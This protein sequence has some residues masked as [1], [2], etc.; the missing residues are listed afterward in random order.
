M[1][2]NIKRLTA[3][4]LA[5]TMCLSLLSANVWAAKAEESADGVVAAQS[6]E[7]Q[8]T[9]GNGSESEEITEI[10]ATEGLSDNV[11]QPSGDD[12]TV[13]KDEKPIQGTIPEKEE[14]S[15]VEE[16]T[17]T[18][19]FFDTDSEIE[20]KTVAKLE[21]QES[22]DGV[23][24]DNVRWSF[25]SATGTLTISGNG[26]M[27]DYEIA[28]DTPWYRV[29]DQ[30]QSI[31]INVGVTTIGSYSFAA[32]FE[33][34][35]S[36]SIP[37]SV[38]SIGE[39]A[40]SGCSKL[41]HVTIPNGVKQIS[42]GAFKWCAGLRSVSIPKSVTYIRD[43][44]F[45]QC[46]GLTSIS[47]SSGLQEIGEDAFYQCTSLASI[48]IPDTVTSIDEGAFSECTGLTDV[49][50]SNKLVTI[51]ESAFHSCSSLKCIVIPESI[52]WIET[53]AFYGC[54]NLTSVILPDKLP[55]IDVQA[56]SE[57]PCQREQGGYVILGNTLV[58]YKGS[59]Q[60]LIIPDG[61]TGITSY[62][63]AGN[64]NITS[65]KIPNSV[66]IIGDYAFEGCSHLSNVEIPAGVKSIGYRAFYETPWQN[67]NTKDGFVI[68]N[69]I[70]IDWTYPNN[71]N[72][73]K[74]VTAIG[75]YTFY[76]KKGVSVILPE[77]LTSIQD[78][79]FSCDLRS[80]TIPS[81]VT[82][83]GD[84]AFAGCMETDLTILSKTAKFGKNVF[85]DC[86]N[87][88]IHGYRGS[89]A[90]AY[91]KEN[92]VKFVAIDDASP[93]TITASNAVRSFSVKAQTFKLNAKVKNKA[94]L[95]YQSSNKKVKVDKNGKVTLPAK[96]SGTVKVTITAAATKTTKKATKTITITVPTVTNV[97]KATAGKGQMTVQWKKNK[98]GKGYVV[99][100]TTDKKFKKGVKTVKIKMNATVK[101]TIKKLKKGTYYVRIRA[102]NGKSYSNWC[103]VKSVKVK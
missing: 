48:S 43:R 54:S 64:S 47:L 89:T 9:E 55:S 36:I 90:E 99:Q 87:I 18:E 26:A 24:G 1:K 35:S 16:T 8:V 73:P 83:I 5:M 101:T 100:Y 52:R 37:D 46:S 67:T 80:L 102:M 85:A 88:T 81:G 70:L 78:H 103:K 62:A 21:T 95:S 12:S 96:F 84:E 86:K 57:T 53:D 92:G 31:V 40:F 75:S 7:E 68:V 23:C 13:A 97:S 4:L 28:N 98:T 77:T 93:N 44:A 20:E 22:Q 10:S 27:E 69:G 82:S 41:N 61:V 51:S 32:V 38:I 2:K 56:F 50:L 49:K 17:V 3:L 45:W 79:A 66:T 25:D 71:P 33:N 11:E 72:I 34:L 65:V 6:G 76:G 58:G 63:I 30:V 94:A 15:V 91:A 14:P 42:E 59:D 19:D 74:S 39:Y 60:T 29:A